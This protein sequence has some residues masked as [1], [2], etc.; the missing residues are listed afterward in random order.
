MS[1]AAKM[2]VTPMVMVVA[3]ATGI[4]V[5]VAAVAEVAMVLAVTVAVAAVM[6][7][8]AV[9]AVAIM[10]VAVATIPPLTRLESGAQRPRL[11]SRRPWP[12]SDGLG[13]ALRG[14]C[15]ANPSAFYRILFP[16]GP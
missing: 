13:Q 14:L 9:A 2:V 7:A 15:L 8:K 3:V 12:I 11:G 6:L 5:V 1:A 10:V 16:L 4:A